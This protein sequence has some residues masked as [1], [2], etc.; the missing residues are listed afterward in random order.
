M[1]SARHWLKAHQSSNFI[2]IVLFIGIVLLAFGVALPSTPLWVSYISILLLQLSGVAITTAV[3]TIFF[4]IDDVKNYMSKAISNLWADG[5]IIKT[6][7]EEAQTKIDKRIILS[8]CKDTIVSIEESLYTDLTLLRRYALSDFMM[9]NYD[10]DIV[11]SRF[12]PNEHFLEHFTRTSYRIQKFHLKDTYKTFPLRFQYQLNIPKNTTLTD[13]EIVKD[14]E[15]RIGSESY[16]RESIEITRMKSGSMN[17]VFL[18]FQKDIEI[19]QY[20]DVFMEL[21]TLSLKNNNNEIVIMRRP[22]QGL[23]VSMRYTDDFDYEGCFFKAITSEKDLQT[24]NDQERT[25]SDGISLTTNDWVLPGYGVVLA[26]YK[27]EE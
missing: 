8:S 25:Y 27:K 16:G 26:W 23:K 11:L 24:I 14:F 6:L 4:D 21:R 7:S 18:K 12:H 17:I 22:T 5:E 1:S 9:K 15:L 20:L 19:D 13:M 2:F 10:I 3:L